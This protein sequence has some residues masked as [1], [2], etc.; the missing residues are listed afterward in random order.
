MKSN[1]KTKTII[2]IILGILFALSPI[3]INN[4]TF[5]AKDLD[6]ISNYNNEFDHNNLKCSA[7]SGK[8]H[9]DGNSGWAAF[10]A[11]GNCT[12]NGTYSEPYVIE[13]LVID[14]GGSSGSC[15]LIENSNLY[16]RIENCTTYNSG[17]FPANA[18]IYLSN[19]NNSQLID[20]NCSYNFEGILLDYSDNNT[21][22]GNIASNNKGMGIYLYGSNNTIVSGNTA[23]YNSRGIHITF[24]SHNNLISGNIVNNNF[25]GIRLYENEDNTISGNTANSNIN[26]IDLW[27]SN[28]NTV[29]GNTANNNNDYGIRLY[30]SD[31]NT[32]SGNT[33]MGNGVCIIEV[34]DCEGNVFKDNEYCDYGEGGGRI[35]GYNL[36]FLF[37]ILS[38][39]AILLSKKVKK[40]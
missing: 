13:D 19:V 1:R 2:L 17:G 23:N 27:I 21:L 4:S 15:I 31:N 29:T 32:I 40:S 22:S 5:A 26:G 36:F 33:L 35:P 39:V 30:S 6:V 3:F 18:G 25:Y 16:F 28:N 7:V 12:G 9:I 11:A 8:I 34:R 20:N 24:Y 37:G 38:V 10:K 14:G